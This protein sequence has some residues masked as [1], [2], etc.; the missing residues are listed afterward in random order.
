VI[1]MLTAFT[2]VKWPQTRPVD[3]LK[4]DLLPFNRARFSA[5]PSNGAELT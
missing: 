4:N 5:A 1:Q 2:H 3:R